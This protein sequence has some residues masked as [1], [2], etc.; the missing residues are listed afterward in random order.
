MARERGRPEQQ[1]IVA[2]TDATIASSTD[3]TIA[4]SQDSMPR[5]DPKAQ[6]CKTCE[7]FCHDDEWWSQ[8]AEVSLRLIKRTKDAFHIVLN[9]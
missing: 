3:A 5:N 7:C 4:S 9:K 8:A 1:H 6:S 2:V